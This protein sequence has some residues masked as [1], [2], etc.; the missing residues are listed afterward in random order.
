MRIEVLAI[1]DELLDGRVA[2]TN[3]LRL[4]DALGPIG[5]KI[6]QRTTITDDQSIIVREAKAIAARGTQVCIVSGGLGPTTD[7][8]TSEA[9]ALLLN[10]PLVR[11][12]VQAEVIRTRLER[13]GRELTEN[14]LKQAERP[15]GAKVIS[16]SYGTAP[17]FDLLYQGCR[18]I[19]VPGVPREFDPMIHN[20]LIE[21]MSHTQS[22]D[23][24]VVLRVF[25]L[26]E[27]QVDKRLAGIESQWPK[28]RL[29]YRAHFPEIQ[30]SLKASMED[31]VQLRAAESFA[32]EALG[33]H[34]FSDS[35][36]P[37]ATSLVQ[38]LRDSNK[39]V[40]LA[41]SCTGGL[42]SDLLTDVSGS[43]QIF[44]QGIVAYSNSCKVSLLDVKEE[45]LENFGAVSEACV[46][47]MA[48]GV[49]RSSGSDIGVGV[50]GIAGPEGGTTEKPVGTV[51]LAIDAD[52]Y[53]KTKR[54]TMPFDRR[55][56]KVVSAH[57]GLDLIRRFLIS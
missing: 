7:D 13:L 39:T 16:N 50:S 29:G 22:R 20:A 15:Q 2:D 45:T 24:R 34:V 36:G 47:E 26:I 31:N 30:V 5:L 53:N 33:L 8:V 56:N 23:S 40:A 51:W 28:V 27:A 18:F 17:G 46:M 49:R 48:R 57:A 12:E 25:G 21:P 6:S 10:V 32:R 38:L 4:A 35:E 52:G 1:G 43:S 41:E 44:V 19:S 14:Q 37:F 9:F 42:M 55:R 11:D 54:L 3:T